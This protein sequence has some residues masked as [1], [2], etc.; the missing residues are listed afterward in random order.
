MS[1]S[2]VVLNK[3]KLLSALVHTINK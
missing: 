1:I 3:H 2:V